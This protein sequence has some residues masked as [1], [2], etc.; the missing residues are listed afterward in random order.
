MRRR[1][2]PSVLFVSFIATLLT[3]LSFTPRALAGSTYPGATWSS[4]KPEDHNWSSE[5][6]NEAWHYAEAIGSGAV[7]IVDDGVVVGQ[8]GA[9]DR[10]W[11][12]YAIRRVFLGALCGVAGMNVSKV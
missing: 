4:V 3:G 2:D 12:C 1:L 5:K 6:L 7:L 10:K 11:P 8:W 9:I